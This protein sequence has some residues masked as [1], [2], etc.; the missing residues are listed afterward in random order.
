MIKKDFV[1][2]CRRIWPR[3]EYI[4]RYR[5]RPPQ[6]KLTRRV[7]MG[8]SESFDHFADAGEHGKDCHI[9]KRRMTAQTTTNTI[10]AYFHTRPQ[11]GD[12]G[13]EGRGLHFKRKFVV[14]GISPASKAKPS[15]AIVRGIQTGNL[16][17]R[18][19]NRTRIANW[20]INCILPASRA[21]A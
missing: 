14:H 13:L 10:T 15:S 7:R 18:M 5:D 1:E 8:G 21:A 6:P 11:A 3:L 19:L 4:E 9:P 20:V 16:A 2:Y 12:D 17:A